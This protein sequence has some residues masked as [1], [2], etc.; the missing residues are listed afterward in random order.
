MWSELFFRDK[1]SINERAIIDM[2]LGKLLSQI[3][4]QEYELYKNEKNLIQIRKFFASEELWPDQCS[5]SAHI[6][7]DFNVSVRKLNRLLDLFLSYP[8]ETE[9]N[10]YTILVKFHYLD[11][12]IGELGAQIGRYGEICQSKEE[13]KSREYNRIVSK[14]EQIWQDYLSLRETLETII[15]AEELSSTTG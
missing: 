8:R 3:S 10:R 5:Y 12:E 15:C 6:L 13:N 2:E 14:L 9:I 4:G 11:K 1:Q 7:L